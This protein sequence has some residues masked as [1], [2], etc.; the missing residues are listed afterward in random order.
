M[1]CAFVDRLPSPAAAVA[2]AEG[3]LAARTSVSLVMSDP[4]CVRGSVGL[5]ELASLLVARRIGGAPVLDDDGKLIG[6]ISKTDLA[7]SNARLMALEAMTPEV[8]SLGETASVADAA[9]LMAG[10][11]IHR[12]TVTSRSGQVV[13]VVST[14]DVARWLASNEASGA[15]RGLSRGGA[16]GHPLQS[17]RPG[18]EP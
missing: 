6:M 14:L 5:G 1:S 10:K 18:G 3:T 2:G 15:D 4:V 7:R 9:A 17:R 8:V 11:G 13:G 16:L 12:V